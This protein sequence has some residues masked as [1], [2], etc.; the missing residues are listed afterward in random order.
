LQ[1]I[2]TETKDTIILRN[3]GEYLSNDAEWYPES[4]ES[5]YRKLLQ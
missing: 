3:I 2:K 4:L 5:S 1:K